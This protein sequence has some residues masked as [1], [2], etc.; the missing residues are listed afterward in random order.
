MEIRDT[1]DHA[2]EGLKGK[3]CSNVVL[4]KKK[5]GKNLIV[6]FI[7]TNFASALCSKKFLAHFFPLSFF[8]SKKFLFHAFNV[9]L[10]FATTVSFCNNCHI[11]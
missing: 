6:L 9:L 1:Y 8:V 5:T 10:Q 11:L 2:G 3:C 7:N 4:L